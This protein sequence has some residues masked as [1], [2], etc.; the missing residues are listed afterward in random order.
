[1]TFA[2]TRDIIVKRIKKNIKTV[3]ACLNANK[4][5]VSETDTYV[6]NALLNAD[7]VS[8]DGITIL[9][10]S[11]LLRTKVQERVTGI[12]L[13]NEI[14]A[15]AE[16]NGFSIF[17]LGSR[18][19]IL[20]NMKNKLFEK[21]PKL[22]ICGMQDGYFDFNYSDKIVNEINN[23]KAQILFVGMSSPLKEKFIESNK[24]KLDCNLIMGVGGSF[25]I[26]SGAIF[27]SPII[28][29]KVGFEW[30]FRITQE[31]ARLSFRYLK[32]FL[33]L[34]KLIIIKHIIK[35]YR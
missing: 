32:N 22:I 19:E 12:D 23:A 26:I 11:K 15:E 16:I 13:M 30:F 21:Y 4:L 20:V 6:K 35:R 17:F 31:P 10:L 2:D 9:L 7:I 5:M 8:P 1:M 27:R 3:H 28:I 14:L 25:D 24:N 33:Y 34:I 18:P 29:R